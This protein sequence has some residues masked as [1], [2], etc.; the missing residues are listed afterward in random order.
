MLVLGDGLWHGSGMASAPG[1]AR[2]DRGKRSAAYERLLTAPEAFASAVLGLSAGERAQLAPLVCRDA[3]RVDRWEAVRAWLAHEPKAAIRQSLLRGLNTARGTAQLR[4][5]H[6]S[7][8]LL[9]D[10]LALEV[11]SESVNLHDEAPPEVR[12]AQ[13]AGPGERADFFAMLWSQRDRWPEGITAVA[14][15]L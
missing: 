1:L 13:P 10:T 11:T 2:A 4:S 6:G 5:L 8:W 9:A 7:I 12:A 15:L 3:A 14:P